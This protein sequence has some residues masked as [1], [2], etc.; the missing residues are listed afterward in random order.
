M[1]LLFSTWIYHQI[2]PSFSFL[3]HY[4]T[5]TTRCACCHWPD[6]S[7]ALIAALTTMIFNSS[8]WIFTSCQWQRE[9]S[10]TSEMSCSLIFLVQGNS[11]GMPQKKHSEKES[12][13]VSHFH[14]LLFACLKVVA[15]V[16]EFFAWSKDLLLE[17]FL[18]I[19]LHYH[20]LYHIDI[21]TISLLL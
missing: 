13:V 2:S 7:Q 21:S 18:F 14:Y 11:K 6:F 20:T 16:G 1:N 8:L 19:V 12:L 17:G 5:T 4:T 9:V 15:I 3:H 10:M